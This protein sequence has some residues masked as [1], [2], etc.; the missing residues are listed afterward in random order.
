[1]P[2]SKNRKGHSKKVSERNKR[3]LEERKGFEKKQREY[4]M[5][6]IELEKQKGLFDGTAS[7][8]IPNY[9]DNVN[10]VV[11]EGPSI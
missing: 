10:N 1:M 11:I 4:L 8:N 9:F 2:K 7:T 5:E 6:L 3:K